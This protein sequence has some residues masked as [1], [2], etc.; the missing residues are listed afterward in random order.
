[1]DEILIS[2]VVPV[3]NA[4]KYIV[5]FLDSLLNQDFKKFEL[6]VVNDGS[7]DK[8]EEIILKYKEKFNY[9]KYIKQK[10]QGQS[11][12]RNKAIRYIRGKYTLFLDPDDY[13]EKNMLKEMYTVAKENDSTS[14]S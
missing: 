3:Y 14:F 13:L 12:A 2:I 8:S 9:F 6:I 1:M 10:N 5:E 7:T 11:E 4:E